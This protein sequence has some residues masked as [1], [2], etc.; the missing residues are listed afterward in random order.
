MYLA[1]DF[2]K[3]IKKLLYSTFYRPP[4]SIPS[5]LSQIEMSIGLAFDK[6]IT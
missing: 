2:S 5:V 3:K 1:G 4:N 6:T